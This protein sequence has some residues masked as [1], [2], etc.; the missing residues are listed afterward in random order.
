MR[1]LG[2]RALQARRPR[3]R[4]AASR[5]G[6]ASI[7]RTRSNASPC[8]TSRRRG[9]CT[10]GPTRRSPRAYYH[11]FFL[12][13]PFDLPERLI[14]AD[15]VYYLRQ[16]DRRLV[17]RD[18][19]LRSARAR[20]IRALLQ[21]SRDHPRDLRGLSRGG[22]RSIS[23][24]TRPTRSARVECPLLVLWGDKGV[25]HRLF[26]PIADWEQRR[27]RRARPRAAL[28]AFPR[29]GSAGGDAGGV[30]DVLRRE[31]ARG[32]VAVGAAAAFWYNAA[33]L[34]K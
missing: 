8:S 15:P 29:R 18:Q 10:A 24:T 4:R 12:I 33:S 5:T 30:P 25:V 3:P 17:G 34:A 19:A 27:R 9:S 11:W 13:Q 16:Q 6:C 31:A 7:T 2:L 32:A 22:R 21:R 20:R 1:A 28:R 14:G 26:D 23:S